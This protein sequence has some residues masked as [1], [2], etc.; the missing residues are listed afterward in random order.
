MTLE[1]IGAGFPRTGTMSLKTALERLDFAPCGHMSGLFRAP[2]R[3]DAWLD[4][5]ER[6]LRGESVDWPVVIRDDRAAVDAPVCVFWRELA[7]AYPEAKVI[8]SVRDP[9]Q[10]YE[11]ARQ[12]VW[13][14]SG[15]SI[16]LRQFE[17][18]PLRMQRN[19]M[20]VVEMVRTIFWD[21]ALGGR[22]D[23]REQA[24][25]IYEAHNAVVRA[26]LPPERLLVWDVAQG[27][28]PLCDYLGVS[29][30]DEPFPQVND[31]EAFL[32]RL[33]RV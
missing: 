16:D 6:T 30:P 29:V 11:S 31:R 18:Y 22:F 3:S 1:V 10:W 21:G 14:S 32:A 9:E 28:Q 17:R 23:D 15:T 5:W 26:A 7:T 19:I 12:T 8:L 24:I 13:L 20:R 25:A 2:S 4:A 27:W 33:D